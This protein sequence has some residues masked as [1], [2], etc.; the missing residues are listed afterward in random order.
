M[1]LFVDYM[2]KFALEFQRA[3]GNPTRQMFY[4]WFGSD[5]RAIT[6]SGYDHEIVLSQKSAVVVIGASGLGK[7]TLAKKILEAHPDMAFISYD[8]ASYQFADEV[9]AGSKKSDMRI[10]EIL[11]EKLME[12]KDRNIVIDSNCVNPANRAALV[13]F[14][15]DLGYEIFI[16]YISVNTGYGDKMVKRA[17]EL[18][19]FQDYLATIDA[20]RTSM[21]ELMPV[22]DRIIPFMTEK[23]QM[24]EEELVSKTRSRNETLAYTMKLQNAYHEEIARYRVEWQEK[25][26][27]F[28]LGADHFYRF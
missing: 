3:N 1:G 28:Q 21:K 4:N 26:E 14:L 2:T 13:R 23:L 19:L 11:E 6:R 8:E 22:R 16:A 12:N 27:L 15:K 20:S 7:T 18:T 25:R 17:V 5:K 9:N 10:V 24:D